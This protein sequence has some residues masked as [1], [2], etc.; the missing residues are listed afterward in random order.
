MPLQQTSS[1]II[2]AISF[3]MALAGPTMF[4]YRDN[5]LITAAESLFLFMILIRIMDE[6]KD[7]EDDLINY[8]E[9]PSEWSSPIQRS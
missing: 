2:L 8:P 4:S 5:T 6:Y 3:F 7:Y 9:S 1:G